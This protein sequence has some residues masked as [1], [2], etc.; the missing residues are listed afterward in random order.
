MIYL[1]TDFEKDILCFS[2]GVKRFGTID[3]EIDASPGVPFIV[4]G[5]LGPI[6]LRNG[7][8]HIIEWQFSHA[9]QNISS[10]LFCQLLA[11]DGMRK[12]P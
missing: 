1:L 8:F 6:N 7:F 11:V 3:F 10:L 12:P 5:W 4:L 9:S 2:G